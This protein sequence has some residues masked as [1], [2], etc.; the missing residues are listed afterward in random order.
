MEYFR[1]PTGDLALDEHLRHVR[2]V[3]WTATSVGPLEKLPVELAELISV[4][5]LD[6]QPRL[7]L[8]GVDDNMLY[9][10]AYGEMIGEYHPKFLGMPMRDG[11]P[12]QWDKTRSIMEK[13]R[14]TGLSHTEEDYSLHYRRNDS[15]EDVILRWSTSALKGR[16]PGFYVS[17]TDVTDI[18]VG[19]HRRGLLKDWSERWSLTADLPS[20]WSSLSQTFAC[21]PTEFPFA[22]LYSAVPQSGQQTWHDFVLDAQD[23]TRFSL[24]NFVG[25]PS[26]RPLVQTTLNLD[27]TTKLHQ[28]MA[29]RAVMLRE[30]QMLFVNDG[31]VPDSWVLAASDRSHGTVLQAAVIVPIKSNRTGV[32]IGLFVLGLNTRRPWDNMYRDWISEIGREISEAFTVKLLTEDAIRKHHDQAKQAAYEQVLLAKELASR[33]K[34]ASSANDQAKRLLDMMEDCGVG[35]FEYSPDGKLRHANDAYYTISGVQ[36]DHQVEL[37]FTDAVFPDDLEFAL[38]QWHVMSQGR[39]LNFEM[40][41]KAPDRAVPGGPDPGRWTLAACIPIL[42]EDGNFSTLFGCIT[43]IDAQKSAERE[44]VQRAEALERARASEQ[45]FVRFTESS[46]VPIY[47]LEHPS[48]KV[49]YGNDAWFALTG[50]EKGDYTNIDWRSAVLEEDI[51]V[52]DHIWSALTGQKETVNVQFRL[53]RMWTDTDGEPISPIWVMATAN[54]EFNDDGTIKGIM[55]TMSDITGFK[56]A[57]TSQQMRINEAVEAKRQQENFIDMTSHE[58]RNPLGAIVHCTDAIADG[59]V[60]MRDLA[61]TLKLTEHV[62]KLGQLLDLIRNSLDSAHTIESCTSH[63]KRIVDDILV[64]SKLDSNLLQIA[65]SAVRLEDVL[66][67][68]SKL[69]EAEAQRANVDVRTEVDESFEQ[70]KATYALLDSGRALQILINLVT[71]AIKFT[72]NESIRHVVIRMGASEARP[73]ESSLNVE[74]ALAHSVRDS[75]YE[76]PE[77]AGRTFHLW[78]TVQDTGRGMTQEEKSKIFSR[79]TQGSPKTYSEY[80]GSGLGLFIS[81][82]LAG[83]QGGEIGVASEA[84]KGSTFAFFVKTVHTDPPATKVQGLQEQVDNMSLTKHRMTAHEV[85]VLVT[86]DNILNQKVLKK[87]LTKHGYNV[88]TADN[89]QQALDFL[90]TTKYWRGNRTTVAADDNALDVDVIL[91]DVE[92][93]VMGGLQ[94][95]RCIRDYQKQG[96]ISGHIPIIA[97]SANARPEQTREAISAGMDDAISKPFRIVEIIPKI[98]KMAS[99]AKMLR[100]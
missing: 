93:P 57:E 40:R 59:L 53:K 31:H 8:V 43:D 90:R 78:F 76:G 17:L 12:A 34:E 33:E 26:A 29:R 44:S 39:S 75:I 38:S 22:L 15:T 47:I 98:D 79:F 36:K 68:V 72:K 4:M 46:A 58:I 52:I 11:W 83:L 74:F 94:A 77:F 85:T 10:P 2:S 66:K 55:G 9:N 70:M 1:I 65:P 60:D 62:N 84:G 97:V 3:D 48:K 50:L 67:N 69:F 23:A 56:W 32:V 28:D 92:M 37:Q 35:I 87:Q 20:L 19:E 63:L 86:E 61:E 71:N 80:G 24:K 25:E 30:P 13:V 54:P 5:L 81:R 27:N 51:Q 82:E 89:G 14:A 95:A 49:T 73:S 64:L 100:K 99:W 16:F 45:R 18:R 42:D 96:E 88:Y 41:W 91:M 21:H 7:L 6:S